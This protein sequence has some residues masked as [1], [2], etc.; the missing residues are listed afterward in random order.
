V[1]GEHGAPGTTVEVTATAWKAANPPS[2]LGRIE[3]SVRFGSEIGENEATSIVEEAERLCTVTNTLHDSPAI[4]IDA[5]LA[6]TAPR[7]EQPTG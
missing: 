5:S 2:R 1:L 6:S 3:L 7:V 4:E